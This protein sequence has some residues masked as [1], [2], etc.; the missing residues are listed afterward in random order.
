M[1][2]LISSNRST[3]AGGNTDIV[4]IDTGGRAGYYDGATMQAE[5][6]TSIEANGWHH[7]VFLT[8]ASG[9]T[10]YQDGTQVAVSA[11]WRPN[12]GA[13]DILYIGQEIDTATPSDFFD[14]SID[15]IILFNRALNVNEISSL[16]NTSQTKF[17]QNFTSLSAGTRSVTGYVV[18][19]A[20]NRNST[21]SRSI[22]LTT[23]G[24][25]GESPNVTIYSPLVEQNFSSVS[26]TFNM[27]LNETG[28][29]WFTLNDGVNNFSMTNVTGGLVGGTLFNYTNSSMVNGRYT[30][31]FYAND[32]SGN[33]N[34]TISSFVIRVDTTGPRVNYESRTLADGTQINSSSLIV[35]AN[36]ED[37]TTDIANIT[38]VLY[39]SSGTVNTSTSNYKYVFD[40]RRYN[41]VINNSD[42]SLSADSSDITYNSV[43]NT[44]FVIRNTIGAESIQEI[45]RT[46][47]L[48]RSITLSGT[49]DTEGIAYANTTDGLHRFFITE[50]QRANITE[51]FLN[52]VQTSLTFNS[53]SSKSHDSGLG[54]IGNLGLEGVAYDAER[55]VVYVVREKTPMEVYQYN[56]SWVNGTGRSYLFNAT[57]MLGGDYGTTFT[58]LAGIYYD[59]NTEHLFILGKETLVVGETYLNGSL[60]RNISM[61]HMVQPEGITFTPFGEYMYVMG[62]ADFFSSWSGGTNYT[63]HYNFT[64]IANGTYSYNVTATDILGSINTTSSRTVHIGSV[65]VVDTTLPIVT[66]NFSTST[67]YNADTLLYNFNVS[68]SEEGSVRFSLDGG[69]NN[70]SMTNVTGGLIGGTLFNYTNGSIADGTY[71]F[72]V[73]ANDT[74]ANVNDSSNVTFIKDAT[75]PLINF[76]NPTLANA[77]STSNGFVLVNVSITESNLNELKFNWNG[78][79]Y[80]ILNDSLR[81][82]LNFDN[83]TSLNENY[84]NPCGLVL[85]ISGNGNNGKV[86]NTT[87]ST[88]RVPTWTS[89]R[90]GG[91]FDFKGDGSGSTNGFGDTVLILHNNSLN[92]YGND[93]AMMFWMKLRDCQD[94]DISRKGST[95]THNNG[96]WYKVEVSPEQAG[97]NKLSLNFNSVGGT[98]ATV[99]TSE[100]Y[101]DEAWHF[102]VAQR[103]G[104]SAQ[105]W[106][107]G[108][109][110]GSA[111]ISGTINNTAN[112]TVGS[113][114]SQN[115][116]YLN[117]T[118]DEY[119][120]Y[121][122]RSFTSSE[123]NESMMLALSKYASNGYTL[124]VNQT[125]LPNLGLALA[126]YTYIASVKDSAGNENNT[127]LNLVTISAPD[128]TPPNVSIIYPTN[129]TYDSTQVQL[130]YTVSSDAQACW[131]S[132]DGGVTNTS[133]T[134]GT[135]VTGLTSLQGSLTWKVYA[136]D[137]SNNINT[138]SMTFFV[139]SLKPTINFSN[140]T[141]I[142]LTEINWTSII[143]NVTANDTNLINISIELF[144]TSELF[145]YDRTRINLSTSVT[146]PY[147]VNFSGLLP[148]LYYFNATATDILSNRN[149]TETR[150]VLVI[151]QSYVGLCHQES[152]NVSN[153]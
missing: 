130:N 11:T 117:G 106:V 7:F 84:T 62:E 82:W 147:F 10:V 101:D 6:G 138:S 47:D 31:K 134:C 109:L 19:I 85:D 148:G 98:A 53:S 92:P 40:L 45:N 111:S 139:D 121:I 88:V 89:G 74:S 61:S 113:K 21:E 91:A 65:A 132:L 37:S 70:V 33:V 129:V 43:T 23:P 3:A 94:C 125:R 59:N 77:S 103:A 143:I 5:S 41:R 27:S 93:F 51:I 133:L 8:N 42:L 141:E 151:N 131:Y 34:T 136:N 96:G 78:T 14:G 128:L 105:L 66:I 146:S 107:D 80:T 39:N 83:L 123:I 118:V 17:A 38:F 87:C 137:S 81:I 116:D 68:L 79:N 46:G 145:S 2:P 90:F 16:Y 4:R 52:D 71:T 149:S 36:I 50:E 110:K 102:V 55:N 12:V 18:D 104:S 100:A 24:G 35:E 48:I 73:Y 49:H 122:N 75:K 142:S 57:T 54:N 15:D 26:V 1:M 69:V 99:T 108:V 95:N 32:S 120:V 58:D 114:D 60:I 86:S 127:E 63:S 28:N 9:S 67:T 13:T 135:N 20:G 72:S 119:R 144:N 152:A 150:R 56:L 44:L 126:P 97:S 124:Y 25:D 29:A 112:L 115:D 140:P 64:N 22:T 76:T 30:L 153:S